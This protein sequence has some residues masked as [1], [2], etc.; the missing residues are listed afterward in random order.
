MANAS[1]TSAATTSMAWIEDSS[2]RSSA[3]HHRSSHDAANHQG[4]KVNTG[5]GLNGVDDHGWHGNTKETMGARR[6]GNDIEQSDTL[7]D[8][9]NDD[10]TI[11][12]DEV[13][14]DDQDLIHDL[15][16]DEEEEEEGVAEEEEESDDGN[17]DGKVISVMGMSITL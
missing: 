3:S 9:L 17:E 16:L 15:M 4:D 8:V 10:Q 14:A 1:S 6:E 5:A 2:T 7:S 11:Y 12:G 13:I